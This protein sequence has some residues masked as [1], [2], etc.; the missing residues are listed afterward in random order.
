MEGK[1]LLSTAYLAPVEYFSLISKADQVFI[2]Y[3]ENYIKQSYRN[4]C[5]ILSASGSQLLSVPVHQGSLRKTPIKEI[6]IDYTKR[7]QQVHLRAIIASYNSSPYFQYYFENIEKIISG[8]IDLLVDLNMELLTSVLKMLK[9]EKRLSC[10]TDFEPVGKADNDFRYIIS[11]KE[12]TQFLSREY[13]QVFDNGRGFVN[14]LSIL[15]LIFNMGPEAVY[16]L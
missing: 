14:G 1:I 5:Y 9:I 7:W 3:R 12:E 8:K 15:D 2:E 4:R 6:R 10:T 13:I 11:P 16:Y